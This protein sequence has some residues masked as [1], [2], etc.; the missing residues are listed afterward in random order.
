[1]AFR[2]LARV[3]EIA[4]GSTKYIGTADKPVILANWEG[5][6]YALYGRCPHQHNPLEG[7]RLWEHLID[8]PWHHYQ[9]DIRTGENHFPGNVYPKDL[10]H[11]QGQLKPLETYPVELRDGEIWVD[12]K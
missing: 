9:Y 5:H 8:C 6:I 12:L 3:E 10:P 7:A 1:V 11:L 4:P 2:K